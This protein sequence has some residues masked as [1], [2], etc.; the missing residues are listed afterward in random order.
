[1]KSILISGCGWFSRR[2]GSARSARTPRGFHPKITGLLS[3]GA[4]LALLASGSQ[5]NA[6]TVTVPSAAVYSGSLELDTTGGTYSPVTGFQQVTNNSNQPI[7]QA[8]TVSNSQTSPLFGPYPIGPANSSMAASASGSVTVSNGSGP[9]PTGLSPPL[10]AQ[11]N[12]GPS[13]SATATLSSIADGNG[14]TS[15]VD[16]NPT[17]SYSFVVSGPTPTASVQVIASGQ[18]SRTFMGTGFTDSY[19]Q[20]TFSVSDSPIPTE[21]IYTPVTAT[22][23]ALNSFYTLDTNTLYTVTLSLLLTGGTFGNN[24]PTDTSETL[25]AIIDPQFIAP[26]GYNIE[27][28]PGFSNSETPLPAALPLFATGLGAIGLL[29]WRRKRTNADAT[30]AA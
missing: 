17:V 16:V 2:N 15:S 11:T 22:T 4:C 24:Q 28:S 10:P 8:G 27:F 18:V 9:T 13:L 19:S 29:G 20:A 26:V 23:F 21:N 1:M 25:S 12:T 14:A 3:G 6:S 5:A 7:S 30:A